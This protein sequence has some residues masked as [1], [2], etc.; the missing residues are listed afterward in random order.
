M[1][2][3]KQIVLLRP[4]TRKGNYQFFHQWFAEAWEAKGL[5]LHR[6]LPIDWR[7]GLLIAK[8]RLTNSIQAFQ[9]NKASLLVLCGGF[10]DAFIFPFSYKYEIIPVIWDCWPKYWD[11]LINSFKRNNINVAFFTSSQVAEWVQKAYPKVKAY[12]LPEGIKDDAYDS[13]DELVHRTIDVLELGRIMPTYH[14]LLI[15]EKAVK[16]VK[17]HFY[18]QP[19]KGFLF[20]NFNDLT[21]GLANAKITIC[22]PRC[23]TNPEMAGNIETLTQRYWECMLSRTLI[24]GRAPQ[25]LIKLVGYNPVIEIDWHDPIMQLY[26]IIANI[27]DHQD[28]VNKN[29]H[30]AQKISSW[31]NRINIVV[32]TL[33]N[34][35]FV[36]K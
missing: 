17:S 19:P 8:L 32:D 33:V 28:L 29:Y 34:H 10:P 16:F 24:L 5:H 35:G 14:N 7:M 20:K 36:V 6:N 26:S 27:Q 13:G 25:E 31:S 21:K 11:R 1:K 9:S 22:F 23:D 18:G 15:S 2:I 4:T 3:P 30:I 12:W